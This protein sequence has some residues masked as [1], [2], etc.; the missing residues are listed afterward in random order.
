MKTLYLVRHGQSEA[1]V[2]WHILRDKEEATIPLTDLG[3][4][5]AFEAG[6]KLGELL[7]KEKHS[8]RFFVSPWTRALMTYRFMVGRF[9]VT[10]DLMKIMPNITEQHMNLVGHEENWAKFVRFRDSGWGITE[11]MEIEFDG[12]ESLHD[13]IIRASKFVEYLRGLPDGPIVVVSHGLFIKMMVAVI[14]KEDPEKLQHPKNCE[15]ITRT[16]GTSLNSYDQLRTYCDIKGYKI[17]ADSEDYGSMKVTNPKKNRRVSVHVG[18]N[19]T[20]QI[21]EILG[22]LENE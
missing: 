11:F 18:L 22:R 20:R 17:V 9:G 12:G 7:G 5:Q 13:V 16:L 1:N 19:S 10:D 3:V 21:L 14:D 4:N 15:I 6:D 8:A 2:D